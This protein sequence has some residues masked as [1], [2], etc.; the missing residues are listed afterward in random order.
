MRLS[1]ANSYEASVSL[2]QKRQS[3]LSTAQTQMTSG[4][5]I[6]KPSDDPAGAA[7]AERA[8]VEQSRG[9]TRLRAIDAS[10]NAMTL[11]E[12]ALGNAIDL[13]QS[14]RE[15]LVAAG[16]GGYSPSERQ[17]LVAQLQGLRSQLLSASNQNDGNGGYLFGGQGMKTAPFA[18]QGGGVAAQAPGQSG[19]LNA[20]SDENLPLS[21]NGSD[22]WLSADS[23]NG[24]FVS[25]AEA[26]NKGQAWINAGQVTDPGALQGKDY[27][28]E[29][30]VSATGASTYSVYETSQDAAGNLTRTL[31]KDAS[32]ADLSG[33][34]YQSGQAITTVAGMSFTITGKVSDQDKF[35]LKQS[36]PTLSV[37]DAI[38]HAVATLSNKN[39]SD[40]Q[41]MQAVNSGI[42]DMDQVLGKFQAAR[43]VVGETMNR[44]DGLQNR[45]DARVLSAKT[46]RSNAED[47]DM[48]QAVSA[49][50]NKQSSYQAAL[51]SYAMVQRL[52]LFQYIGN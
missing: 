5:R 40:S 30:G 47:L 50:T 32:G 48:V 26:Q 7:R 25:S 44:L 39:A 21:V 33:K 9:E 42:R 22:I 49:F 29:F 4:K 41:V 8:L 38:D 52:S 2:L 37:F 12:S 19:A 6:S 46:T 3:E 35:D 31:A 28:I 36:S 1:T 34:P 23:G 15:A 43:S 27:Q 24:S 16:N 10:R 14:A 51:Q 17:A 20:A 13:G 45:T 11:T 18:D